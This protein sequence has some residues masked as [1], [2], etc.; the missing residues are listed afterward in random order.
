M[1]CIPLCL[2]LRAFQSLMLGG[3]MAGAIRLAAAAAAAAEGRESDL[4]LA[5]NV[6]VAQQ[7]RLSSSV[8]IVRDVWQGLH[9]W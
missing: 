9:C 8:D 1:Q 6:D 5:A 7:N 4:M 3:S 2:L